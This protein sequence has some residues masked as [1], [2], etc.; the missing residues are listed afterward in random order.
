[1]PTTEPAT[2]DIA[3]GVLAGL[4]LAELV[5][6]LP[7]RQRIAVVLRYLVD[8]PLVDVAEAM[9]CAVGTVK[10]TL[11]SA[12]RA[13]ASS[14]A[15]R[16]RS[17]MRLDEVRAQLHELSARVPSGSVG[18]DEVF[19]QARRTVKRRRIARSVASLAVVVAV[20]GTLAVVLNA[21]G[22]KPKTH[23]T[24]AASTT[25]TG[26]AT[27][28]TGLT[29]EQLAR[30][31]R[32]RRAEWLVAGRRGRRSHLGAEG[33]DRR[34]ERRMHGRRRRADWCESVSPTPART[35]RRCRHRRWRFFRR[36]ARVATL[37][38]GSC[39]DTAST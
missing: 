9:G 10:S 12:P 23:V 5:D 3:D 20:V 19:A 39:T 13:S 35:P 34:A 25:T 2:V 14:C 17:P 22:P 38:P 1:M 11:H 24:V 16:R 21:S 15:T 27:V 37:R 32:Y 4:G 29:A 6:R 7:E 36:R 33:L 31:R 8:L 30:A 26:V 28:P 18:A